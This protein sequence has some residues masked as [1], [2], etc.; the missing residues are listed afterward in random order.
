MSGN[1][2]NTFLQIRKEKKSFAKTPV[3]DKPIKSITFKL[4]SKQTA[5]KYIY[6]IP[7]NTEL[8]TD[9]YTTSNILATNYGS[10]TTA[11]GEQTIVIELT[12]KTQNQV[13]IVASGSTIY[14]NEISV[15]C[16]E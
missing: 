11:A 2:S 7:A 13:M 16:A 12:D 6:V 4:N 8:I 15:T 14:I 5:G 3:F 10:A 1:K 9:A